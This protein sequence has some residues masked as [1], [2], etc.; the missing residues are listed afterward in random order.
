MQGL[1]RAAA[2]VYLVFLT[3]LL[4]TADPARL[5]GWDSRLLL[6]SLQPW[7]HLLGFLTM[8]VLALSARW[9]LPRWG[10]VL[11]LALYAGMTEIVQG[12]L[13]P[14]V[15][16]WQ[17]WLMDLAGIAIGTVLCW[18]AALLAGVISRSRRRARRPPVP[19]DQ[20]EVLQKVMS[21]PAVDGQ[22]WWG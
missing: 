19:S 17:D 6:Q 12:L 21:R 20:W 10:V 8:A 3:L 9:P 13:P 15:R 5:V 22:S 7:A 14:R 18:T 1:I 16:E 11:I 4:L 2:I